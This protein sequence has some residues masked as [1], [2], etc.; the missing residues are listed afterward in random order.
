[1][2]S[3][4]SVRAKMKFKD[5]NKA[6]EILQNKINRADEENIN[7]GLDTYRKTEEL[8]LDDIDDLIAV[9]IGPGKMFDVD[10]QD[11]GWVVY[12]NG[13]D[14]SYGWESVMM[15]MFIELTPV[16]E[17]TSD[18]FINCDDGVDLLVIRDG[19]WIQEM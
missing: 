2:G 7:Y 8:D 6:I 15:E 1:M 11:D 3:V 18:L 4:Y 10:N 5:V 19:K 17:D 13:F 9:F 14:A 12:N 16:L